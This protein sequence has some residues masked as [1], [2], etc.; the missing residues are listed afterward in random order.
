MHNKTTSE[1]TRALNELMVE[2][3]SIGRTKR[4]QYIRGDADS[5]FL[6]A[7]FQQWAIDNKIAADF[8]APHHQ[9]MNGLCEVTWRTIDTMA[10]TMRIHARLGEHFFGH[11]IQYAS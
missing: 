9:E 1:V 10:R 11:S 8:A 2:T 3:Q 4:I 7:E 5:S 6:S